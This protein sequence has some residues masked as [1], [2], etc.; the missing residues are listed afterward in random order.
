MIDTLD[1]LNQHDRNND[2]SHNNN[3]NNNTLEITANDMANADTIDLPTSQPVG[4]RPIYYTLIA[5]AIGSVAT[6]LIEYQML[7]E[8]ITFGKAA[9]DGVIIG[10]L[11]AMVGL[12]AVGIGNALRK[13]VRTRRNPLA[14]PAT[15]SNNQP[16]PTEQTEGR[17]TLAFE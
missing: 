17:A 1:T 4:D 15:A 5:G 7:S 14:G 6:T 3:N 12:F 9:Y 11:I 10:S 16:M 13:T 8:V 2:M